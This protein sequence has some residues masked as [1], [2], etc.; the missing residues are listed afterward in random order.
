MPDYE[1]VYEPDDCHWIIVRSNDLDGNEENI[2]RF[3]NRDQAE[4]WLEQRLES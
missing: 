3:V 1:I 2:M 4:D